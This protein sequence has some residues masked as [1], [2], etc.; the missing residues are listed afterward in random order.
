M[1]EWNGIYLYGD[2]CS[3]II[4]G[5]IRANDG[6]QNQML[7]DVD[8]NITSFGQDQSGELYLVDDGGGVFRFARR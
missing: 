3:G 6:W 2:Y 8:I 1:S 4:W 7:F 5:L